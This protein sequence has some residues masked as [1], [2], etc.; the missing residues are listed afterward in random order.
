MIVIDLIIPHLHLQ[1]LYSS[2][3]STGNS[4]KDVVVDNIISY[5]RGENNCSSFAP[6]HITT[7]GWESGN[8]NETLH[9]EM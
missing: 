5:S 7:D 4:D 8:N 6:I 3:T 2:H 1:L 9:M